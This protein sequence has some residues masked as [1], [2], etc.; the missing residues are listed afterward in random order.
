MIFRADSCIAAVYHNDAAQQICCA[1]QIYVRQTWVQELVQ[2][3]SACGGV[4]G[5]PTTEPSHCS[6]ASTTPLPQ[7]AVA[8][9]FEVLMA[10]AVQVS[11]PNGIAPPVWFEHVAAPKF[12]PSHCSVLLMTP[13]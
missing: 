2:I 10:H 6:P 1:A 5:F 11:D 13:L 8:L 7:T 12:V 3:G 4:Q 9:Q